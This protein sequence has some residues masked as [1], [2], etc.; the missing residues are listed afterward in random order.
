MPILL[1]LAALGVGAVVLLTKK[2]TAPGTGAPASAMV[3]VAL[4]PAYVT[5]V[6]HAM[7][8]ETQPNNLIAFATQM[9]NGGFPVTAN[10]LSSQATYLAA[11]PAPVAGAT[12][13]A[14][15]P[16]FGS[17]GAG[18]GA[19]RYVGTPQQYGPAGPRYVGNSGIFG[20]SGPQ[21][22]LNTTSVGPFVA[23]GA[24]GPSGPP[25]AAPLST[26]LQYPLTYWL[27]YYA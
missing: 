4:P 13:P 15:V 23:P 16:L 6:Q 27:S 11:H 10:T 18:G 14:Q 19:P 2:T 25:P 9:K 8:R 24:T 26:L 1:L 12:M 3:D 21:G 7:A 20:Q 17:T 22:G 5:P